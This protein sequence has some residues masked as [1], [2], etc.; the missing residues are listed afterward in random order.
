MSLKPELEL[1]HQ[2]MQRVKELYAKYK[3]FKILYVSVI[4]KNTSQ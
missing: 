1:L 3:N 4:Y 2:N